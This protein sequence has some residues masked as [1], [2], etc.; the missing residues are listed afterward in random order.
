MLD[1]LLYLYVLFIEA[2]RKTKRDGDGEKSRVGKRCV[3]KVVK[4][5]T[6]TDNDT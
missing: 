3:I 6:P 4:R 1:G 2:V 5:S